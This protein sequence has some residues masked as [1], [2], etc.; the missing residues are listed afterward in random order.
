VQF[1][2]VS[3]PLAHASLTSTAEYCFPATAVSLN[4]LQ[5]TVA[6]PLE[7]PARRTPMDIEPWF[8]TMPYSAA[9]IDIVPAAPVVAAANARLSRFT[10]QQVEITETTY[11][12][13]RR[14][15]IR[16]TSSSDRTRNLVHGKNSSIEKKRLAMTL[17]P[18]AEL[19][20]EFIFVANVS[21]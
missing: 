1:L 4:V 17:R 11:I 20:S 10:V 21:K 8:C 6:A 5:S 2:G 13:A 14:E 16:F 7:P 19:S 15:C 3:S 18:R 9:G 12:S